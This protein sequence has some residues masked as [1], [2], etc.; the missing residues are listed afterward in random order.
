MLDFGVEVSGVSKPPSRLLGENGALFYGHRQQSS[1]P[2]PSAVR[3]AKTWSSVYVKRNLDVLLHCS[4][5]NCVP[6]T[7]KGISSSK[8]N[9]NF[10]VVSCV[11]RKA[12]QRADVLHWPLRSS[13]VVSASFSARSAPNTISDTAAAPDSNSSTT[14]AAAVLSAGSSTRPST[15]GSPSL[16]RGNASFADTASVA[17]STASTTAAAGTDAFALATTLPTVALLLRGGLAVLLRPAALVRK[18]KLSIVYEAVLRRVSISCNHV[19][20]PPEGNVL[21][22]LPSH[23]SP[24]A[25]GPGAA[26]VCEGG[27]YFPINEDE[28]LDALPSPVQ[29]VAAATV[30][31]LP[32]HAR[33]AVAEKPIGHIVARQCGPV[34]TDVAGGDCVPPFTASAAA[35]LE[36]L[37]MVG[38]RILPFRVKA[39][40]VGTGGDDSFLG[41]GYRLAFALVGGTTSVVPRSRHRANEAGYSAAARWLSWGFASH[42]NPVAAAATGRPERKEPHNAAGEAFASAGPTAWHPKMYTFSSNGRVVLTR[43]QTVPDRLVGWISLLLSSSPQENATSAA[44]APTAVYTPTPSTIHDMVYLHDELFPGFLLIGQKVVVA[45]VG[46]G[47]GGVAAGV[48]LWFVT[49]GGGVASEISPISHPMAIDADLRE[50]LSAGVVSVVCVDT[51]VDFFGHLRAYVVLS[52]GEG[53]DHLVSLLVSFPQLP[54][55]RRRVIAMAPSELAH[56][57]KCQ[58]VC[59]HSGVSPPAAASKR[60]AVLGGLV[61]AEDVTLNARLTLASLFDLPPPGADGQQASGAALVEHACSSLAD[62]LFSCGGSSD[63]PSPDLYALCIGAFRGFGE[64]C[65]ALGITALDL[66]AGGPPGEQLLVCLHRSITGLARVAEVLATRG[67]VTVLVACLSHLIPP[68]AQSK[69]RGEKGGSACSA[70]WAAMVAPLVDVAYMGA[71]HSR[72]ITT[73]LIPHCTAA[74]RQMTAA[75]REC[76]PLGDEATRELEQALQ[77]SR[78]LVKDVETVLAM[79]ERGR[80]GMADLTVADVYWAA[81]TLFLSKGCQAPLELL[82]KIIATGYSGEAVRKIHDVYLD[83]NRRLLP[84]KH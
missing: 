14:V 35:Q 76:L 67:A 11:N 65:H 31:D 12:V 77:Q 45:P 22:C 40:A 43:T 16:P 61:R 81:K 7:C 49:V 9:P 50:E 4:V 84:I 41:K 44:A 68:P 58:F 27:A 5:E 83:Y 20:L 34:N 63:A 6:P 57:V 19:V 18:R 55:L 26:L 60:E 47:S 13:A 24:A 30:H 74:L 3:S 32:K 71:L 29:L 80:R 59:L 75:A 64:A 42:W 48:T 38:R 53:A 21:F 52:C 79:V 33:L 39:A 56:L 1:I 46:G 8:E 72:E 78:G 70:S 69:P 23:F 82:S 10:Y 73:L 37:V 51:G 17:P 2:L 62:A 54:A 36:L 25:G 15:P 66:G 28:Q